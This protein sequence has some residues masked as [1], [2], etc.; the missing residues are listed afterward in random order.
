MNSDGLQVHFFATIGT[1]CLTNNGRAFLPNL[2][3]V[4]DTTFFYIDLT[5]V[6][7]S[8]RYPW[9]AVTA[10]GLKD[11]NAKNLRSLV[12]VSSKLARIFLCNSH[13][14]GFS[15]SKIGDPWLWEAGKG[16]EGPPTTYTKSKARKA[17][18]ERTEALTIKCHRV[19]PPFQLFRTSC[20]SLRQKVFVQS[21]WLSNRQDSAGKFRRLNLNS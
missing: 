11:F 3:P 18:W 6:R 14:P 12:K 19:H 13:L 5:S 7:L 21:C 9:Q 17:R 8:R 2:S 10:K 4:I 20:F 15:S 16:I 1:V